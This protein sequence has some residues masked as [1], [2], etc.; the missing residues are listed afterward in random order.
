MFILRNTMAIILMAVLL[1]FNA[2]AGS[3]YD[4][5][6]YQSL[7]VDHRA[8]KVGD[9]LTVLVQEVSSATARAN[10][11]AD[12]SFDLGLGLGIISNDN[13]TKRNGAD[14]DIS[15]EFDGGATIQRTGRLLARVSVNVVEV[16]P[17]GELVVKGEQHIEYNDEKQVITLRGKVR[18]EDIS[19]QNTVLSSRMS[20]SKI[21]Y[22]GDGL[23]AEEQS[24][25]F[26]FKL[27]K[28]LL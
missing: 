14:L 25:G 20:D 8:H 10:T 11:D 13:N 17:N 4:E 2:N 27:L 16:H 6:N 23:L 15:R 21:T 28:W 26:I 24:P 22:I 9:T 19:A 5:N 3:L 12:K 7:H 18:P 1:P